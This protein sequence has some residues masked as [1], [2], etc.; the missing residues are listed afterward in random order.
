LAAA[1]AGFEEFFMMRSVSVAVLAAFLLPSQVAAGEPAG[2]KPAKIERLLE[3]L[4]DCTSEARYSACKRL[5][6]II[7]RE[8]ADGKRSGEDVLLL[9]G[10]DVVR[11]SLTGRTI[12]TC[13]FREEQD[14]FAWGGFVDL[15]GG[16]LLAFL[17][18]RISDSGVQVIRLDPA[19]GKQLW[20]AD[21][22]PLGVGH[23][24]YSH[25]A[26]V[27]VQRDRVKVVSRGSYG[28]FVETLDLKSGRQVSR[29][30]DIRSGPEPGARTPPL[31]VFDATGPRKGE[32]VDYT[33]ERGDRPTF[34][35]FILFYKWDPPMARF[36]KGLDEAVRKESEDASVVA[37]WL[38][39]D[40]AKTKE[41]L[42]P[43][44]ETL[45]LRNTALTCCTDK[46]IWPKD[47][48]IHPDTYLTAVVAC[49][50]RVAKTFGRRSVSEEDVPAVREAL[51]RAMQEGK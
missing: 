49:R 4:A 42:P 12:W 7:G 35:V 29:T 23:S 10:R 28:T 16:G 9:T 37:V 30:H 20:Q 51:R 26:I 24:N 11:M 46:E 44:Q 3:E 33:A 27:V 40:A 6:E 41:D 25:Y 48:H 45:K 2:S 8:V 18:N 1:G 13:G 14:W 36:L 43:I 5:E 34:Y 47:W 38:T 32:D 17:Y 21:C 22:K 39:G 19:T 15:P 50:G 31:K